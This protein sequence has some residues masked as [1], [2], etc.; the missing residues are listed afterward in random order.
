[1]TL[2]RTRWWRLAAATLLTVAAGGA[3]TGVPAGAAP[4]EGRVLAAPAATAVAGSYLVVLR[5]DAV[6]ESGPQRRAAVARTAATIAARH[7]AH[8]GQVYADTVK[9]F[10]ARMPAG[11]AR[12]LAADPAVA[13]VEQDRM[14]RLA[15]P[16]VQLNPPSWGLDRIDQRRLPLDGRYAYP[17]TA[18]NVH[19]Y[20][21][22]TGVR[23]THGDFGGRAGGGV[24]L[25]DGG[26]ADDCNGHGTH[27]A[28]TVGGSRYGVAKEVR[29]R[30]VRVLGC[31]G[32]GSLAK[33]VAGIDWVTANAARPAVAL[34]ALGATASATLDAAVNRSVAAGIPYVVTAGSANADACAFSPARV[35]AALTVAGTTASDGRMPSGNYGSCLDLYAPGANI[36]SAWHTG[37][38]AV[39]VLSGGS[40]AAAHVAGCVALALAANPTWTPAQVSAHLTGRATVG[41]VGSVVAG[42]PNRLLYCGP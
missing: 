10:Q 20:V 40:T 14:V 31:T 11:V 19:A 28:G 16:G 12:R 26:P 1:M 30:P 15:G 8:P 41:V 27:L 17:N 29:L 37:D 3:A 36:P 33:V 4:A 38:A 35:P 25:V 9:G 39:A 24:D 6:R 34:L 22:D 2:P 23:A 21:L 5:A 13:W 42:T 32:S 18:P 7:G